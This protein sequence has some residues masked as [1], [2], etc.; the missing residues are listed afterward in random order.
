[1]TSQVLRKLED[2]SLLTRETD[3]ADTRAKLL[4]V[5]PAGASLAQRAIAVVETVDASFFDQVPDRP[6]LLTALRSL[7]A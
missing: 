5:T 2:K 3:P 6:A 4:R 7:S 1:M